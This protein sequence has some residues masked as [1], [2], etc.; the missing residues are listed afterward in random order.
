MIRDSQTSLKKQV[1]KMCPNIQPNYKPI[2]RKTTVNE[3]DAIINKASDDI[4]EEKEI[5]PTSQVAKPDLKTDLLVKVELV[6]QQ[7]EKLQSPLVRTNSQHKMVHQ[8]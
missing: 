6:G 5:G 1:K 4:L 7:V 2:Q 8:S 3:A